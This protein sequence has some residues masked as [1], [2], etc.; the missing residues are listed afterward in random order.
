MCSKTLSYYNS[1]RSSGKIGRLERT[2]YSEN[3]KTGNTS[4]R[5]FDPAPRD[6]DKKQRG[7]SN[8]NV[9]TENNRVC[10]VN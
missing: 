9:L 8:S 1:P 3:L 5:Y 4:Y 7:I 10:L 6:D 2:E